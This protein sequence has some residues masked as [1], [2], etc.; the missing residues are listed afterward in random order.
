MDATTTAP[1]IYP[2]LRY[3]DAPAA[4][5]FLSKAFGF[6][7]FEVHTSSSGAIDHA[8]VAYDTGIVM[9]GSRGDGPRGPF[10]HGTACIYVA[11]DD[12][13]AHHD[14]ATSAGAE[15]VHGLV[16]QP[17][18]SREYAARDPEGNVWSFGTYR[19]AATKAGAQ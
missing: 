12:P 4:I 14:A 2:T 1:R 19:P 16:D 18:G 13:D 17:Y 6:E 10:D 15:I 9:I 7:A 3:D 11:V 8:L 5:D